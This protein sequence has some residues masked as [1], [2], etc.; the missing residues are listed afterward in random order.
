MGL[1]LWGWW[2]RCAQLDGRDCCRKEEDRR[3]SLHSI[4]P[5]FLFRCASLYFYPISIS[6]STGNGNVAVCDNGQRSLAG[7]FIRPFMWDA[8]T[9]APLRSFREG[10]LYSDNYQPIQIPQNCVTNFLIRTSGWTTTNWILPNRYFSLPPPPALL[11]NGSFQTTI[12]ILNLL[13]H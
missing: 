7:I 11:S 3:F 1:V 4:R 8:R 6:A 5:H 10:V 13:P 2:A 9:L 12:Q